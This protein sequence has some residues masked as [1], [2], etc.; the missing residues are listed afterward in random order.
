M[1]S[2]RT[3]AGITDE[4]WIAKYRAALN[5]VPVQQSRWTKLR[6][7]FE[8]AR[9]ILVRHAGHA[10]RRGVDAIRRSSRLI[11]TEESSSRHAL[12]SITRDKISGVTNR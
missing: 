1:N 10:F 8:Q 11:R 9:S 12:R 4:E 6:A 3:P 2:Q 7:A 5:A